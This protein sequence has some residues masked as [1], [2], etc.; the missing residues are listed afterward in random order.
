MNI[1][2]FYKSNLENGLQEFAIQKFNYYIK[3]MNYLNEVEYFS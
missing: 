2:L 1:L 3:S